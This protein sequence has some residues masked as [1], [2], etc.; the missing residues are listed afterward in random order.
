MCASVR[1]HVCVCVCVCVCVSF[2]HAC[3]VMGGGRGGEG[4]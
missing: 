4:G 2:L 1:A 3:F